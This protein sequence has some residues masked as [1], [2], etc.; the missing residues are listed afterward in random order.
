MRGEKE[1]KLEKISDLVEVENKD[2][3]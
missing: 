1:V 2:E 3:Y